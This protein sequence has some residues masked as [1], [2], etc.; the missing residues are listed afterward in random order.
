MIEGSI[1][2]IEVTPEQAAAITGVAGATR[3]PKGHVRAGI[4]TNKGRGQNKARRKMANES[5]RRNRR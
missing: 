4:T 1:G 2:P 3:K 5:R